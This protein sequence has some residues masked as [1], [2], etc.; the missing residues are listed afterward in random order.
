MVGGGLG[1]PNLAG[2]AKDLPYIAGVTGQIKNLKPLTLRVEPYDCVGAE[3]AKPDHITLVHINRI[4]PRRWTGKLP[5]P[6]YAGSG[7]IDRD[8]PSV[9]LTDP[10]P[11]LGIRP[12]SS[13]SLIR[14][15][16]VKHLYFPRFDVDKADV[17]PG[18]RS[19]INVPV[20]AGCDAVWPSTTRGIEDFDFASA[21][22]QAAVNTVLPGK[23]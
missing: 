20:W 11:A 4:R 19:I 8:L 6:P 17:A 14:C 15:W 23:P 10:N 9:P 13:S 22:I 21:G 5:L 3:I 7:I 18:Q 12:Y 16:R 1:Q 2:P